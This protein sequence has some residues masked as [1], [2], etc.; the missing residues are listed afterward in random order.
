MGA[1][2]GGA[3]PSSAAIRTLETL[4]TTTPILR[5]GITTT[6]ASAA[7]A[8]RT[9][10]EHSNPFVLILRMRLP[11]MSEQQRLRRALLGTTTATTTLRN[12]TG[13]PTPERSTRGL[14]LCLWFYVT[15]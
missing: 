11:N 13:T 10:M 14:E 1:E 6:L 9:T 5:S 15:A 4:R 12:T 2:V 7:G 3:M 8:S